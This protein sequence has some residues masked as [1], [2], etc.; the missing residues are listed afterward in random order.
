ML[1]QSFVAVLRVQS[2][3]DRRLGPL[4]IA[5]APESPSSA[6]S[7]PSR[8]SHSRRTGSS[9]AEA[10][11]SASRESSLHAATAVGGALPRSASTASAAG[12]AAA[13]PPPLPGSPLAVL[14]PLVGVC[15]D[16]AQ[17]GLVD[18]LGPKAAVEV[19]LQLRA[20]SAGQLS[21]PAL[22]LSNER[23]GRLYATLPPAE[24]FVD[25]C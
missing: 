15:L 18:E 21:L 19:R 11:A 12:G 3:V 10:A 1:G 13:G 8:P 23:D 2:H 16:G 6:T 4:K 22:A 24:L 14:P 5:V 25:S 20:L 17:A 7:S 9:G